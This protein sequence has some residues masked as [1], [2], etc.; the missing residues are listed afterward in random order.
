[1]KY[2]YDGE[3][4]I[5]EL[6]DDKL[7]RFTHPSASSCGQSCGGGCGGKSIFVDHPISISI[8]GV[9]YYY[10]YDGLGS[11]TE[12]I[13]TDENV[14]NIYRYTPFGEALIR[15]ETIYNPHQFTG[16]Q[17]DAESGLYHYRA[18]AYSADIGRFMQQDPAGMVDEANVY[19]YVG[20]NPVNGVDPSGKWPWLDA[21]Y[22]SGFWTGYKYENNQ[23]FRKGDRIHFIIG[24]EMG[25]LGCSYNKVKE[26][27]WEIEYEMAR[28]RPGAVTAEHDITMTLWGRYYHPYGGLQGIGYKYSCETLSLILIPEPNNEPLFPWETYPGTGWWKPRTGGSYYA[29]FV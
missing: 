11:V 23:R 16:R 2:L 18:R 27:A 29:R 6:W 26:V 14:V 5:Y 7:V 28:T 24:C 9:K 8:D 22:R 12:L 25:R 21:C 17:Y 10:L 3:N 19:A 4:V 15:Q 13:D 1:M 20:N